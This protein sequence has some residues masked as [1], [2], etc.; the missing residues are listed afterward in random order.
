M[1]SIIQKLISNMHVQCKK[2]GKYYAVRSTR[3]QQT[4]MM[5]M[6]CENAKCCYSFRTNVL[7]SSHSHYYLLLCV[8]TTRVCSRATYHTRSLGGALGRVENNQPVVW[9]YGGNFK[10]STKNLFSLFS[11]RLLLV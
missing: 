3:R 7:K 8:C 4:I 6:I 1:I 2:K 11:W 9:K 10:N 5:M